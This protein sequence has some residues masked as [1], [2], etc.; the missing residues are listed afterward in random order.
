MGESIMQHRDSLLE[1]PM[2]RFVGGPVCDKLLG[3]AE[4]LDIASGET[5]YQLDDKPRGIYLVLGGQLKL[6]RSG[7][8]YREH[9]VHL[10]ERNAVFGEAAIFLGNH[11]TTAIA[12]QD[13]E[14][15]LFPQE[16]FLDTMSLEPKLQNYV[17]SVM[18]SWMRQLI[19]KIDQL[20]LCDGAQRVA[21]Y[22]IGLLD[23][24]PY[25]DFVTAVQVELPTRKKDLATMLNMNQPSLSRILRQLQDQDLID[26]KGRRVVLRDIDTLRAMSRLSASDDP[27]V[28]RV[29]PES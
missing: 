11:P 29:D 28:M 20:T 17:L 22:L 16:P 27:P 13:S 15:L 19:E 10:A 25:S 4:P 21:G 18:A 5:L 7:P 3:F 1:S 14:L 23:K 2:G 26:V 6:I 9:I 12:L 24:S 8:A